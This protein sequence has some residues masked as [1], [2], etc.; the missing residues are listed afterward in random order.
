VTRMLI[1]LAARRREWT[2]ANRARA[3]AIYLREN[4][5]R[6]LVEV[7]VEVRIGS[8]QDDVRHAPSRRADILV[9]MGHS[10][11]DG[12]SKVLDV[13][14]VDPDALRGAVLCQDSFLGVPVVTCGEQ[15]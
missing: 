15:S 2:F 7:E 3:L 4:L 11:V 14:G 12:G 10:W 8:D 9:P 5:P 1:A 6:D 13:L